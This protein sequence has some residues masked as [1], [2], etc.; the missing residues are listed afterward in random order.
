[1]NPEVCSQFR[2]LKSRLGIRFKS[3]GSEWE[4]ASLLAN[5]NAKSFNTYGLTHY[6]LTVLAMMR[7]DDDHIKIQPFLMHYYLWLDILINYEKSCSNRT[8]TDKDMIGEDR[9]LHVA[10]VCE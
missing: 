10:E 2:V 1:M 4:L 5:S 7:K 3:D 6:K 8:H 9:S